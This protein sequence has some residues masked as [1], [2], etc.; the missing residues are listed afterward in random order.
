[1]VQIEAIWS[2]FII[3]RAWALLRIRLDLGRFSLGRYRFPAGKP[4]GRWNEMERLLNDFKGLDPAIRESAVQAVISAIPPET[5]GR[6]RPL[7]YLTIEDVATLSRSSLVTLGAHSHSHEILTQVPED[8][9]R[10]S[11]RTSKKLLEEWTGNP[12]ECFAYP[13]GNF[14]AAVASILKEEGFRCAVTTKSRPWSPDDSPYA[15]PRFG[16]GRFEPWQRFRLM[17][18]GVRL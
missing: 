15:I 4:E 5:P 6:Q 9:A 3:D 2:A 16:I 10:A 11:V 14:S 18:A 8:E 1:M 7:A 17:T 13:N 12:I